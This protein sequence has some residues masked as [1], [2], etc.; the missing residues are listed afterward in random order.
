MD[1]TDRVECGRHGYYAEQAAASLP[2]RFCPISDEVYRNPVFIHCYKS[3]ILTVPALRDRGE[4]ILL[5]IA[6]LDALRT[7][8]KWERSYHNKRQK[9]RNISFNE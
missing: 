3:L 2:G 9:V 5:A 7:D 1:G 4:S 8:N 6:G